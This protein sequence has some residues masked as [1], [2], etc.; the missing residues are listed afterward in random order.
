MSAANIGLVISPAAYD[1]IR[2]SLPK[3]AIPWEARRS[4]QGDF[5]VWVDEPTRT[6][7]EA[8]VLP[9]ECISDAILRLLR[10]ERES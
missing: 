1:A 7:V 9:G 6:A 5:L 10:E 4:P 2:A 8:A 3:G